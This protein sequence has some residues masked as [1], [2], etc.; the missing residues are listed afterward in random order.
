[1]VLQWGIRFG[2]HRS[3]IEFDFVLPRFAYR[4]TQIYL[5]HNSEFKLI[6]I[7]Q[8]MRGITFSWKRFGFFVT[9]GEALSGLRQNH[10]P[11]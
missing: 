3:S 9:F 4:G 10:L 11:S 5:R 1:M 6:K 2:L 7:E 8:V